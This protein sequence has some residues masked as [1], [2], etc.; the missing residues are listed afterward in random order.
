M[1]VIFEIAKHFSEICFI[2][3]AGFIRR[4]LGRRHLESRRENWLR[5]YINVEN[6]DWDEARFFYRAEVEW[7]NSAADEAV[8]AAQEGRKVKLYLSI[9]EAGAY[10]E[11]EA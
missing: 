8:A 10:P 6:P 7:S 2:L 9:F 1:P 3:T 5:Y 4:K 11:A